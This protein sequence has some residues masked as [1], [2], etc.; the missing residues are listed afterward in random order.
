VN[1]IRTSFIAL[2][3]LFALAL[4]ASALAQK[5]PVKPVTLV[6]GTPAG[7]AIDAYA[8]TVG[9]HMAR[10]LGQPV[11]VENKP[12]AGGNIATEG[13]A[14][15][16]ADGYTVWVGTQAMTEIYPLSYDNLRWK[17][18]DFV[19]VMK[20]VEAPLVLVVHASV[21]AKNL[22]EL[23]AWVKAN[24]GKV[25][26]ASFSPGTPSHFL[27]HQ[28]NERLGLDMNHVPF[29]G[30]AP[31]TQNLVG[32][33][34]LVG[35]AQVQTAL[36]H[37]KDGKLRALATTGSTRWRQL[38]DVP[39][40]AELGHKDFT[41]TIWFGLLVRAGTPPAVLEKLVDAARAA[42]A[43]PGVREKLEQLGFDVSGE[44]DPAF[45]AGIRASTERWAKVVKA[46]GFKAS[47]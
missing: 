10:T 27:G 35:F 44:T 19:G 7:G 47:D 22:T 8:R 43:D 6:I 13:I 16:P 5:W 29:K 4:A 33:H 20:G 2:V 11:I 40:L 21:P 31:Q 38:P 34:V 30:S 24:P 12:G 28:L 37:I 25:S 26:Y 45:S 1:R 14:R 23:V 9:E 41:A 3:G 18:A 42:H 32:G 15:A 39:T 36:P 17:M 46:T